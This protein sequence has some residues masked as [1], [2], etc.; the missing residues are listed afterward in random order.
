MRTYLRVR[1]AHA[2]EIAGEV[3]REQPLTIY[4]NGEKFLTL[5]CSPIDLEALVVGYLWMEKV[6]GGL[7]E[8]RHV[9][10]SP[11]DGRAEVMLAGPV[12]LPTERILT[13][14]CGGGITFRIDHRLF[15][16]L[17]STLRVRP[18]TLSLRM[19]DLF[20]AAVHYKT[21]RG[22]HGAA[23]TDGE[24]ILVVAEDVGRHNAVDKIK[25]AALRQGI[26]TE[27]RILLSTG[28]I[29]SEMLLKAAR[30][31]VPLVASRTSPTEMAVA[32]AEQLNITVCGYVRTDSLNLYAGQALVLSDGVAVAAPDV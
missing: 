29:S 24:R 10:V 19:K 5:L 25:G 21:S 3:V 13:S 1:G 15:P 11:V 30:M 26:P 6:I 27:D 20:A 23:L 18:E 32:L 12:T 17:A 22:I 2:D 14:G 28:R 9:E 7:D 31:G 8:I 4:V 16:R